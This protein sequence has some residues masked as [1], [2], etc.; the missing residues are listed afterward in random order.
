[1]KLDYFTACFQNLNSILSEHLCTAQNID[2][3]FNSA[4]CA[5]LESGRQI[6]RLRH[7]PV[8][9]DHEALELHLHARVLLHVVFVARPGPDLGCEIAKLLR[10]GRCKRMHIL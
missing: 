8:R 9:H 7:D 2:F 3:Q 6:G 5:H 10:L 1:M 4:S